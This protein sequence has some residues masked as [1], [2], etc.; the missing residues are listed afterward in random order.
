MAPSLP[1]SEGPSPVQKEIPSGIEPSGSS[2][3]PA[4]AVESDSQSGIVPSAVHA[5]AQPEAQRT[6]PVT[7]APNAQPR[8]PQHSLRPPAAA[9][10]AGGSE[11]QQ[12]A[13][14]AAPSAAHEPTP[15][16][17]TPAGATIEARQQVTDSGIHLR[18]EEVRPGGEELRAYVQWAVRNEHPAHRAVSVTLSWKAENQFAA[19]N[20]ALP[21]APITVVLQPGEEQQVYRSDKIL[22][23]LPFGGTGAEWEYTW[24]LV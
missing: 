10:S 11:E 15:G 3:P 24:K 1:A 21:D 22:Q 23:D 8:S 14:V 6:P 19:Y 7:A 4:E 13:A 12:P 16:D 20:Y 18:C 17:T 5:A 9:A 2:A